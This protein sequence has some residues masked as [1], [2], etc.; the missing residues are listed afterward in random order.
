MPTSTQSPVV[1]WT[2]SGPPLSPEHVLAWAL[3][4]HRNSPTTNGGPARGCRRTRPGSRSATPATGARSG[5]RPRRWHPS[6]PPPGTP[7]A[8][9][10]PSWG[11]ASRTVPAATV[12]GRVSST[13]ARSPIWVVGCQLGCVR[14][15]RTGTRSPVPGASVSVP[16]STW[17]TDAT[18]PSTQWAAV[19][20]HVGATSTPPQNW[21]SSGS[22]RRASSRATMNGQAWGATPSP[23]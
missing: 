21:P 12:D 7:A 10:A 23:R 22:D 18:R 3:P 1:A 14:I 13:S 6:P 20:T 17:I 5:W 2:S 15:R 9:R 16:T 8:R 11:V 19:T 4:P